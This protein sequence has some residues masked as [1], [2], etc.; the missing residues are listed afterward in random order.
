[1]KIKY[2]LAASVATIGT[3]VVMPAP[4]AAQQITSGIEGTVS[5]ADGVPLP[6]M[7]IVKLLP[8]QT[9]PFQVSL[10][11]RMVPSL[12]GTSTPFQTESTVKVEAV[13]SASQPLRH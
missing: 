5:G 3:A 7:P 10:T 2:L 1:M 12:R 8:L 4:L 11:I 13:N 6:C 9:L